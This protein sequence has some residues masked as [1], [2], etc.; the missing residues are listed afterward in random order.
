M[1][2]ATLLRLLPALPLAA[3]DWP[4][5]RGPSRTGVASRFTAP[6]T[7]PR[8]LRKL[9]STPVGPSYSSPVGAANTIFT[10]TRNGDQEV[11]QSFDSATGKP[12]W[13]KSY[14]ATFEKNKY[15]TSMGKGPF[16]TPTHA[17][18]KLITFGVTG[19]LSCWN[20]PTGALLWRKDFTKRVDTKNLFTGS[21]TSPLVD[22]GTLYLHI[23]DDR[24]GSLLALD[25]NTGNQ[26]W[27]WDGDGPS[28]SS[29]V[30]AEINGKRH[31]ITIT[32]KQVIGLDPR[33]GEL[34]WKS[35]FKDQW[36]E[37]I[38]TPVVHGNHV[39]LSGV[40]RGTFALN[41]SP[42]PKI[43]WENNDLP[44]YMSS[45]VL[46]G[47]ALYGMSSKR[48]GALFC[49]DARTGK[50]AWSTT[51]REG[52]NM[53]LVSAGAFLFALNDTGDLKVIRKNIAKYDE[54]TSY[55]VSEV[56]TWSQPLVSNEGILI[57][58]DAALTQFAFK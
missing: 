6:A 45:P 42:A 54:V 2:R 25:L 29:P 41:L 55:K 48:K 36:N 39:I 14:A 30:I 51:G 49:L 17:Q 40:R 15:A 8:Q 10:F 24:A 11:V 1:T 3:Q 47:D 37:N 22:A 23:G 58:D 9:W 56:G 50:L 20:A 19:I 12:R 35:D 13:S 26:K 33:N 52:T 28:Y 46:D 27:T 53:S 31:L 18:D 32:T 7:W 38:I 43:A 57:K 4:Q 21:A 34:F 44:M 16:S 5:W